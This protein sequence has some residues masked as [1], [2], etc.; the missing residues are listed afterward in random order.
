MVLKPTIMKRIIV[1]VDF[2]ATAENAALYAANVAQFY[3]ADMW[4][5]YNYSLMPVLS[6]YAYSGVSDADMQSAAMFELEEFK[7]KIQAQLL[8]PVNISVKAAG[9]DLI[10][11]LN[12]LCEE[13]K[14]DMVVFG[15]SGKN[16]LARLVVGSNTIRAIHQLKYPVLVVPPKAV[17]LPVRKVGFACDYKKIS[18]STPLSL[19]KKVVKDFNADLHV[20]NVEYSDNTG[21]LDEGSNITGFFEELKPYYS[22]IYSQD[23]THG[24]NWFAE[25]EKIDW[26]LMIPRQHNFM[27]K[28]FGRSQTKELLYHTKLPVLCMHD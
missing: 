17:F 15:L 4:L 26:I 9:G 28:I 22:A 12:D 24:I 23:I 18:A 14:P 7:K 8:V 16:A 13:I 27:D 6:E 19:L 3:R 2:S 11:A 21:P 25:K 20:L 5:F 10:E 1:P